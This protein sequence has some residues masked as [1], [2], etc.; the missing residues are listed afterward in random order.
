MQLNIFYAKFILWNKV[1]TGNLFM[2]TFGTVYDYK[3]Y[4]KLWQLQRFVIL[5]MYKN[6]TF[7]ILI[8]YIFYY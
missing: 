5:V 2:C 4:D 3:K 7:D 1:Y 8:L 6:I